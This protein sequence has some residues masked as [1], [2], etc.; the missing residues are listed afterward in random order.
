MLYGAKEAYYTLI[1][2]KLWG[3]Q[4]NTVLSNRRGY[5]INR[6][7]D[8]GYMRGFVG[9]GYDGGLDLDGG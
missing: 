8:M 5:I 2:I 3:R 7:T 1:F 9:A 4:T 6:M